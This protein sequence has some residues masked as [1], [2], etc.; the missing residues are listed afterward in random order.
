MLLYSTAQF[1]TR[2]VILNHGLEKQPGQILKEVD[3]S[4]GDYRI[5]YVKVGEYIYIFHSCLGQLNHIWT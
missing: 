1:D 2:D 5:C 3:E 4:G